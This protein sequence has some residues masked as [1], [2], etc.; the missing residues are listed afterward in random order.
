MQA[1][2]LRSL[3]TLTHKMA[4]KTPVARCEEVQALKDYVTNLPGFKP[5]YV[6]RLKIMTWVSVSKQQVGYISAGVVWQ[7]RRFRMSM[8]QL[9]AQLTK[10]QTSEKPCKS[11]EQDMPSRC[12][13]PSETISLSRACR[14]A[15]LHDQLLG[16]RGRR[17]RRRE[18]AGAIERRDFR[19]LCRSFVILIS[20]EISNLWLRLLMGL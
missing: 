4:R 7:L 11:L 9:Q 10:M 5:L 14:G 2:R 20:C 18:A 8:G 6:P 13:M 17:R 15:G 3:A 12:L 1:G 19:C 16:A